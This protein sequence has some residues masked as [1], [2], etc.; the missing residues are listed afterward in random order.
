MR[1][2]F[3]SVSNLFASATGITSGTKTFYVELVSRT[4]SSF[5]VSNKFFLSWYASAVALDLL[6]VLGEFLDFL[7]G[8][9]KLRVGLDTKFP[10]FS[11]SWHPRS[12]YSSKRAFSHFIVNV[13]FKPCPQ[14]S[15]N[16]VA[17]LITKSWCWIGHVDLKSWLFDLN[18]FNLKHWNWTSH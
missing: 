1:P 12:K 16:F 6:S 3:Q 11:W 18:I 4:L 14:I 13:P 8:P 2:V 9:E 7:G 10:S 17:V 5:L 15:K